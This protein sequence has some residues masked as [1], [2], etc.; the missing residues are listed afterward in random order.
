[1]L[2][3]RWKKFYDF[4]SVSV[5]RGSLSEAII[6]FT[7]LPSSFALIPIPP[8]FVVCF[9]VV[10]LLFSSNYHW[11]CS[12]TLP[13]R[14]SPHLSWLMQAEFS[15]FHLFPVRRKKSNFYF[16]DISDKKNLRFITSFREPLAARTPR[17]CH[18]ARVRKRETQKSQTHIPRIDM[19][20]MCW[21]NAKINLK[22]PRAGKKCVTREST[23]MFPLH[24][25]MYHD[26]SADTLAAGFVSA[27]RFFVLRSIG[28]NEL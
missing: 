20:M 19:R 15:N 3:T 25:K 6:L 24:I 4:S 21:E 14:E 18:R 27:S 16:Y 11:T 8:G 2:T 5:E 12:E 9:D 1:M 10:R 17:E 26:Q 23:K 22:S 28:I 7:Q 13:I